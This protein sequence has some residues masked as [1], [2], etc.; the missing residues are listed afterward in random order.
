MST[1]NLSTV[2]TE[3]IAAYGITATNVINTTRYGSERLAEL[4]DQGF[5]SVVK[6][7]APTLGKGL[8]SNLIGTQQRVSGFYVKGVHAGTERAQSVVGTAVD[9]ATKGV[10]VVASNATRLDRAA[11]LNALPTLN[12]VVMPA[13]QVVS[14]VAERI[15]QGSSQLVKRVTGKPMPAKA[16]ATRKLKASTRQAAATR[17][18]VTKAVDKKLSQVVAD[19]AEMGQDTSKAARRVTRQAASTAQSATRATTKGAK[20]A[21][22]SAK[23][24][25]GNTVS[26]AATKTS[27]AARRVARKAQ[28]TAQ[29]A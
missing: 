13:A 11:N 16:L 10:G 27:N 15:E 26:Q 19:V 1:K 18:R 29:A 24:T 20:R 4:L 6:R 8:R 12:R 28:A 21:S 7:G 25:V 9:L 17:K 2:A 22:S 3:V 23:K 5:A 14:Q